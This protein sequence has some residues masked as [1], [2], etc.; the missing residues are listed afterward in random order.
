MWPWC[1]IAHDYLTEKN[2]GDWEVSWKG[3]GLEFEGS[4]WTGLCCFLAMSFWTSH[5]C[6]LQ[7][8]SESLVYMI[9]KVFLPA[10]ITQWRALLK[11]LF[12]TKF[13][14]VFQ[15]FSSMSSPRGLVLQSLD[16]SQSKGA[17]AEEWEG[18]KHKLRLW[19]GRWHWTL[20]QAQ[21]TVA[22]KPRLEG[23]YGPFSSGHLCLCACQRCCGPALF[24]QPLTVL[25]KHHWRILHSWPLLAKTEKPPCQCASAQWRQQRWKINSFKAKCMH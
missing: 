24:T 1:V 23:L 19:E 16:L 15:V 22:G 25:R 12:S 6:S 20:A 10:Q 5:I 11:L 8:R 4:G 3:P 7:G 2:D 18:T 9:L 13:P 21:L 17:A 14:L